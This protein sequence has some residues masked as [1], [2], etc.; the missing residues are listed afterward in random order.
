MRV[1]LTRPRPEARRWARALAARGHEVVLLPLIDIG[2]APDPGALERA[3]AALPDRQAAMFV[4]GNAVQGFFAAAGGRAWPAATRAWSP[5]PGTS[6]A[7]VAAGV[8]PARIDAPPAEAAQFDSEAL[9]PVIESQL[10]AGLRVLL[11]RGAGADG[12]PAGRDWLAVRLQQAGVLVD[13]VAAYA[14]RMPSVGAEDLAQ[15]QRSAG[16]GSVWLFSSSESIANLRRLLPQQDWSRACAIATHER[17]AQ[18]AR[19]AGFGVVCP[20]RPAQAD[21]VAALESFG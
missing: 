6:Q 4:S 10:R 20:S 1:V 16:D 15:A 18:A 2:P 3:W 8:A 9:W 5:G 21:V 13:T 11:V 7:L 14:R 12:R 19:E 17:I